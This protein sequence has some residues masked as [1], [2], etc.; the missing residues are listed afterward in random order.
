MKNKSGKKIMKRLFEYIGR[1][2]PAGIF[3]LIFAALSVAF[4]LYIPVLTGRAVDLLTPGP[5]NIDM[6]AVIVA[7]GKVGIA[8]LISAFFQYLMSRLGNHITYHV[9]SDIRNDAMKK[10]QELSISY[11]DSHRTGDILSRMITDADTFADG[12]L[13]GF[14]QLFTGVMTIVGTLIFM[15]RLNPLIALLVVLITPLSLVVARFIATRSHSMFKAQSEARGILTE[16]SEEMIS[17]QKTVRVFSYEDEAIEQFEKA[18]DKLCSA[19]LKAIFISSLTN[20]STRFVNSCVYALVGVGGALYSIGG[21]ISVGG[22]TAFLGYAGQYTKPFNEIS[23]VVTE[24]QNALVCAGRI[25]ELIDEKSVIAEA[26]E[27]VAKDSVTG[28]VDIENVDF[29]Y[30]P[31]RPLIE[32]LNVNV[33]SGQRIAIVGPTG[34]GKTTIINLLMRFYEPISGCIRVDGRD[35][36][37]ISR[38]DL[39]NCYGMVL[40]ET[41]LKSGTIMDNIRMGKPGASDEEVIEAAKASHAH[42]FIKRLE[43]G[44]DTVIGEEGEGLSQGQKQLLCISRVMLALPPMLILD[45]ATS[46]IDTRT[47]LRI[48]SAFAK[49][50]KGRTS[51]IVA[52]RLSTI[53][54]AD[55]ILV[56]KDGHVIETGNHESLLASKGFYYDLYTAQYS[57][58]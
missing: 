26:S 29:S 35:I 43:N 55:L 15:V 52:H 8:A 32:G 23:G 27:P 31:D 14:T 16:L 18:D 51:F 53:K 24:F 30:V 58:A 37:E 41:W 7:A 39:R 10:I 28:N 22:L 9:V 11:L 46:S 47:E 3:V 34:C 6:D 20:P 48:Q 1:Y 40:Q 50:M 13:M 19:S 54:E 4:S 12:L 33:T 45:E 36:R 2:I 44:Y 42:G 38:K 57:N 5:G 17:S 25:F 21:G 49:L 56:M